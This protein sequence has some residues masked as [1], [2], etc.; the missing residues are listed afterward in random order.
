MEQSSKSM[1][2]LLEKVFDLHNEEKSSLQKENEFLKH[3]KETLI[4]EL[5]QLKKGHLDNEKVNI[6]QKE[7]Q[8]LKQTKTNLLQEIEQLKR[9]EESTS[10]LHKTMCN[11][12]EVLN[13]ELISL[14]TYKNQ[15]EQKLLQERKRVIGWKQKALK[16]ENSSIDKKTTHS[17]FNALEQNN[18][19]VNIYAPMTEQFADEKEA[20]I[21]D[22]DLVI[23]IGETEHFPRDEITVDSDSD[24]ESLGSPSIISNIQRESNEFRKPQVPVTFF[25][26]SH[27]NFETSDDLFADTISPVSSKVT[28]NHKEK[29]EVSLA[30]KTKQFTSSTPVC[31]TL[32]KD[33]PK[34]VIPDKKDLARRNDFKYVEVIRKKSERDK[35][36]GYTCHECEKFYSNENLSDSQRKAI[37]DRCSR[38]RYQST[39]PPSTPDEFWEVGF[40]STQEYIKKGL[41]DVG[42]SRTQSKESK[43]GT[44]KQRKRI[45]Y[46]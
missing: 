32:K 1:K 40:P 19:S 12:I 42:K 30:T 44:E 18:D 22:D 29:E 6:L 11:E 43:L 3:S 15:M 25:D 35:L 20:S 5:K 21:V 45:K 36:N 46:Q 31:T 10:N 17:L 27:V 39:P 24:K 16:I 4:Q 33:L 28:M 14:K 9:S 7:I 13:K 2:I 34:P 8:V 26:T 37:L 23:S 41:L 38:H